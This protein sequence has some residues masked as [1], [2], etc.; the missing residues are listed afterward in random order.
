MEE[1]DHTDYYEK[2]QSSLISL[3]CTA[4][5]GFHLLDYYNLKEE[6]STGTKNQ[7][8]LEFYL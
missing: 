7:L 8:T 2:D 4:G 6:S 3:V 1:Y 5:L